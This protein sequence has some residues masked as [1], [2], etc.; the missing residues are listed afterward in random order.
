MFA[1]SDPNLMIGGFAVG[2][3][4]LAGLWRFVAWVREAPTT[5]DPWDAETEQKLSE[6]E[7]QEVCHHCFA[8]Q[9]PTAWFCARCGSAVGPYNN[10]MPYV[11]VFSE[12]EVFRNGTSGR[13]RN[14]P[15]VLLG[16]FLMTLGTFPI[17]API[18]LLSL[19]LNWKRPPG[20]P[21]P[22]E[23]QNVRP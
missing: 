18:Y 7:A 5:P 22:A 6:P 8:P 11:Q 2:G 4:I 23:E 3:L 9:P 20:E 21:K 12:G 1:A 14:R 16:Y 15:L 13:F 17:F 10:L 19:L